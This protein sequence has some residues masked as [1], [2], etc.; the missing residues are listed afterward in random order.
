MMRSPKPHPLVAGTAATIASMAGLAMVFGVTFLLYWNY[1]ENLM[2]ENSR[3]GRGFAVSD[4][5]FEAIRLVFWLLYLGMFVLVPLTAF[6]VGRITHTPVPVVIG[7]MVLGLVMVLIALPWLEFQ[8]GCQVG[9]SFLI[10]VH[11]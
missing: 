9:D 2:E 4:S 11:C 5:Q 10:E 7:L 3:A 1:A 6:V 8:N